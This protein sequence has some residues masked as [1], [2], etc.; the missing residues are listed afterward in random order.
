MVESSQRFEVRLIWLQQQLQLIIIKETPDSD[1]M[2]YLDPQLAD[3]KDMI[4][5]F[6]C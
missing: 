4:E 2:V 6:T 5:K 3:K 1:I